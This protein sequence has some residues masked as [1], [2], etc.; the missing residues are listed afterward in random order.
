MPFHV[1][2]ADPSPSSVKAAELALPAPEFA[3]RVF[4]DGLDAIESI[5]ES[6]PDAVLAAFPL[7]TRDGYELGS[8]LRSQT[9]GNQVALLFLRGA[10]EPFD[11]TRI[12]RVAYDGIVE[13]P[14]DGETLANLVRETIGQKREMPFLPEE[15]AIVRAAAAAPGLPPP[16][17]NPASPVPTAPPDP[18]AAVAGELEVKIRAIVREELRGLR[19]KLDKAAAEAVAAEVRRVL[20]EELTKIDTRKI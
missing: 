5:R 7:P 12:A 2:V 18:A 17:G 15:P 6:M 10:F 14:F 19:P 4:G 3:L 16:E 9:G 20:V 13:K 11:V 8:F 1:L